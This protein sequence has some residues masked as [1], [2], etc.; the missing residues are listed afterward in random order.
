MK[1]QKSRKPLINKGNPGAARAPGFFEFGAG[2]GSRTRLS[3]L[4]SRCTTDV[5]T[6]HVKIILDNTAFKHVRLDYYTMAEFKIQ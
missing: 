6:L 4:G 5:L 1:P 3:G 2:Y